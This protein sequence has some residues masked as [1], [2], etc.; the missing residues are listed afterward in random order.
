MTAAEFTAI[1]RNLGLTQKAWGD[2]LGLHRVTVVRVEKGRAPV[3]PTIE[4]LVRLYAA[5]ARMPETSGGGDNADQQ[6]G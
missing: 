6:T 5:G 1:R 2:W 4:R 3:T